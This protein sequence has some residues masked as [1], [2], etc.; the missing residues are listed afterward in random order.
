MSYK[1]LNSRANQLARHLQKMGVKKQDY[2]GIYL[3]RSIDLFVGILGILKAGAIYVPIDASYPKERK[4]YM[5]E[6][7]GLKVLITDRAFEDQFPKEKGF[8]A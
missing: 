5:I 1:E 7:T 3:H 6:D 4:L 8:V 2:V